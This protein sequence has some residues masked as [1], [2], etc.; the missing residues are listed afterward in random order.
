L[1]FVSFSPTSFS[2]K[3]DGVAILDATMTIPTVA[4]MAMITNIVFD[5]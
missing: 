4:I 3:A 5:S 2:A 1:F